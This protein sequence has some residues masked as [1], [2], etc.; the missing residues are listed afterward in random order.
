MQKQKEIEVNQACVL[1]LK[2]WDELVRD[3][4]DV[5]LRSILRLRKRFLNDEAT[6]PKQFSYRT[7]EASRRMSRRPSYGGA[8][9]PVPLRGASSGRRPPFGGA[10][11]L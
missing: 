3:S 6:A 7:A 10:S 2:R 4:R 5:T 8:S 9:R 1:W 11:G